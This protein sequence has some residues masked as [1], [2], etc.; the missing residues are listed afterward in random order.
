M[1]LN[2]NDITNL[3]TRYRANLINSLGGFKSLVLI[4]T[5]S[6][7]SND[8]VAVFSSLF[9]LGA[10]PALCGIVIRPNEEKQ[11]TLGNIMATKSYTIN[12]VLPSF[13]KQAH[14]C[15]AKYDDGMS[16]F[17]EV[18]LTPEFFEDITAPFVQQSSIK[19]AC[20]LV[21]KIDIDLNGTYIIIGKIVKIIAPKELISSD[22]FLDLEKAETVTCSGL[23]SYH[24]TNRIA[25]LSYAK[26]DAPTKEL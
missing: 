12:Q 13:I 9:H 1:T 6:I 8:N 18:G 16:E 23:D 10:N 14:Q 11:N 5:R 19:F 3:E 20:E 26:K 22:G 15:S 4:G 2:N 7:L 17:N 24:T 21:Q 25:R